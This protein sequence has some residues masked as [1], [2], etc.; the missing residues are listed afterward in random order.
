MTNLENMHTEFKRAY[1]DYPSQDNEGY[2]PDR[3]GF[4][5]GFFAAWNLLVGEVQRVTTKYEMDMER[6]ESICK[7]AIIKRTVAVDELAAVTAEVKRLK[8]DDE[9]LVEQI[10]ELRDERD[11]WKQHCETGVA[12]RRVELAQMQQYADERDAA[13]AR[14]AQLEGAVVFSKRLFDGMLNTMST[15]SRWLEGILSQSPSE[16]LA[17]GHSARSQ[18]YRKSISPEQEAAVRMA[19]LQLSTIVN[20]CHQ[21]VAGDREIATEALKAL[22]DAFGE[23]ERV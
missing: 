4:K 15:Q 10:M 16:A 2:V 12:V 3:G 1:D 17:S 23:G 22:T 6:M 9:L 14:V 19:Q 11:D 7:S 18:E 20:R 13:L 8:A 5:A 21:T